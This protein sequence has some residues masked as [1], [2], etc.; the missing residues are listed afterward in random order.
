[1]DSCLFIRAYVVEHSATH[2]T[3][4]FICLLLPSYLTDE[5]I[6]RLGRSPSFIPLGYISLQHG[7]NWSCRRC[8]EKLQSKLYN[9]RHS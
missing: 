1:V 7:G 2:Y 5:H 3:L 8:L 9:Q 4:G 6:Q